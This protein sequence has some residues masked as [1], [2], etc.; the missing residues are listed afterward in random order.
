M[1]ISL[2]CIYTVQTDQAGRT[3]YKRLQPGPFGQQM[4]G[5]MKHLRD[6]W[7]S[8]GAF[9]IYFEWGVSA[10]EYGESEYQNRFIFRMEGVIYEE[11]KSKDK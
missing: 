6:S 7:C 3:F 8:A 11:C 1:I 10:A 5:M 4:N 9:Y 2:H